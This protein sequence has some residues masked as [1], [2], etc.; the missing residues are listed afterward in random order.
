MPQPIPYLS[1]NGNCAEAVNFYVSALDGKLL[2]M[3]D[4]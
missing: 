1:F 2:M 4:D 3:M